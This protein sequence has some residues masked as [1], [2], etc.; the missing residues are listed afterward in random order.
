MSHKLQPA[1]VGPPRDGADRPPPQG[2]ASNVEGP[3]K[4]ITDSPQTTT[5]RRDRGAIFREAFRRGARDA[6][7]RAGR[8]LPPEHRH[9]I[10]ALASEYELAAGD[11]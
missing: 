5:G 8:R 2:P 6:L 10:E 4:P 1:G 3:P 11:G 9:I 7:T